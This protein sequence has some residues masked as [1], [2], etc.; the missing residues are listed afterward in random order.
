MQPRLLIWAILLGLCLF[1]SHRVQS[2]SDSLPPSPLA[3]GLRGQYGFV[4]PHS[5]AIREIAQEA[6]PWSIEAELAWHLIGP[7]TWK[8][9]ANYP[10]VGL[11][12]NYVNF[13]NPQVIGEAFNLIAF[14]E[15]FIAVRRRFNFSFRMGAG[16]NYLTEPFDAES[17]PQNEFYSS[18]ISFILN[19]G[20][21]LNYRINPHWTIRAGGVYN[22]ISNGGI[23]QPNKGINFPMLQLGAEYIV[24]PYDFKQ[25]AKIP[26][27]EM[28]PDRFRVKIA[29]FGQAK[30]IDDGQKQ[31]FMIV[32]LTSYVSQIIG[33]MSALTA[34][35]EWVVDYSLR[36]QIRRSGRA[37]DHN[38]GSFLIGHEL[39]LG[40][41]SFTQQLGAYFYRQDFGTSWIY[42]R[43][44]LEYA[45]S[46][47]VFAGVNL[48]SHGDVAEFLDFRVG[49]VF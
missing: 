27:R 38:R 19:A 44:G 40:R 4:I 37:D 23:K 24:R 49:M 48:K 47:K 28:H 14:F 22:H 35:A 33:R 12:L 8:N 34:G 3:I 21:L 31:R 7:K 20:L 1:S 17:N 10:R 11:T 29:F 2:Q 13:D 43:Y 39:L 16:V 46:K 41:F 26:W 6:Q 30:N 5:E 42:Q 15:P 9:F 32:G 18:H 25:K 45:I 36:E